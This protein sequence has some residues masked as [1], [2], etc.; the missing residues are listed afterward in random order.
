MRMAWC[1]LLAFAA[2]CG[3]VAF[4]IHDEALDAPPATIAWVKSLVQIGD[5]LTATS[6]SFMV[7]ADR[8]GDA[9]LLS[10]SCETANQP[11]YV[12]DAPGWTLSEIVP[13][14]GST[15]IGF[16]A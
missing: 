11:D 4:E 9:T 13:I 12:L 1:T 3:R 14:T 2:G 16:W 10:V 7:T 8:A 5:G 15:A 6:E